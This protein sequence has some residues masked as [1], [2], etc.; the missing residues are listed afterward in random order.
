MFYRV[1]NGSVMD[2]ANWEYAED[3][4][5]IENLTVVDYELNLLRYIVDSETDEL[6]VNPNYEAE[7]E[8]RRKEEI[9]KLSMTKLDFVN[10]LEQFGVSYSE[11]KKL[12]M[13]SPE[14]EKQWDLCEKVYRFNP[15][16]DEY[17]SQF[18]IT[19]EQL[20]AMFIDKSK[21]LDT[22]IY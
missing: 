16:L 11:I 1:K 9:A 22:S 2:Y 7:E 14:A 15:L 19:P 6:I 17:C 3:C 10:M 21:G 20:D 12:I 5:Y 4:K 8:A 13:S 18:N